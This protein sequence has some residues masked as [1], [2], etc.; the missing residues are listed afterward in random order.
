MEAK[1]ISL[2][3]VQLWGLGKVTT[4]KEPVRHNVSKPG[5]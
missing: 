4:P 1:T 5:T 2:V 3:Y